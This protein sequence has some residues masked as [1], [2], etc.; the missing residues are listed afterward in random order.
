MSW[1]DLNLEDP[2]QLAFTPDGAR[3]LISDSANAVV[4]LD[5]ASGAESARVD[6]APNAVLVPPDG[7]VAYAAL[8][9]D[10]R[11]AVIDLETLAV[12]AAIPTG[13]GSGPGC[14]FWLA[15]E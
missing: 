2:N 15:G 13:T 8:R 6:I 9:G 5:A 14:M 1:M 4:V 3:V 12:T 10:H 11:I 7:A